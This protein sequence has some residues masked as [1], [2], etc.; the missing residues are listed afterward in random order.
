MVLSLGPGRRIAY[1]E[2]GG[3]GLFDHYIDTSA[4]TAKRYPAALQGFM[5]GHGRH[6]VLFG[7]NYPM[8]MPAKAL[9]LGDNAKRVLKPAAQ[10]SVP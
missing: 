9:F 4:Y 2:A 10:T 3:R 6:K 8:I 5:R 7:I 1:A